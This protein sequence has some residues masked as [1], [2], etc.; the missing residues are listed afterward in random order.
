LVQVLGKRTRDP[1]DNHTLIE[2]ADTAKKRVQILI[3]EPALK[4]LSSSSKAVVNSFF[5]LSH[6]NERYYYKMFD[7][8]TKVT[9]ELG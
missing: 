8:Y 6:T 3:G 5:D 4:H 9:R 7:V 2:F 1:E